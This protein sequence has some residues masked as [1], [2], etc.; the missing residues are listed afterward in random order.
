MAPE[1]KSGEKKKGCSATNKVAKREYTISIHQ[2]IHGVA[3]RKHTP[4]SLKEMRKF[5]VKE[6]ETPDVRIVIR[7]H[8]AVWA[9]GRRNV[10]Y[11]VCVRA[12]RKRH[13]EKD[14]PNSLCW[15]PAYLSPL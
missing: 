3:F 15:S 7:L 5:A 9:K 12:F 8:K 2:Q 4:R 11:R 1:K 13:E 14:S 6:M 10:P